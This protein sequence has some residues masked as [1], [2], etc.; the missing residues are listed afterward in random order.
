MS[1][2]STS[3]SL[4]DLELS[5]DEEFKRMMAG[6]PLLGGRTEVDDEEGMLL[7]LEGGGGSSVSLTVAMELSRVSTKPVRAP[8]R[9]AGGQGGMSRFICRSDEDIKPPAYITAEKR[10]EGPALAQRL[11]RACGE[12]RKTSALEV[13]PKSFMI[14][15]GD[16]VPDSLPLESDVVLSGGVPRGIVTSG[17][18]TA[19]TSSP[20]VPQE[21]G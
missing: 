8:L 1:E 20:V 14:V 10:K 11:K 13:T 17:A 5:D 12:L 19:S 7:N 21:L 4:G 6:P 3:A 9:I 16:S 15:V 2:A 18:P